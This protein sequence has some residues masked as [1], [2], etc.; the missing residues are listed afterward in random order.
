MSETGL[1]PALQLSE[2]PEVGVLRVV[3]DDIAVAVVRDEEGVVHAVSDICSHA[4]VS[5][6]PGVATVV[7]DPARVTA[8][9][10]ES[11]ISQL[12]YPARARP[13]AHSERPGS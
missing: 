1:R 7:A 9:Q 8:L 6:R 2:L 5:L 4:E 11:V 13:A 3:I 12:G 10:I